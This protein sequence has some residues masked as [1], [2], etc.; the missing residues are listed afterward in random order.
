MGYLDH[1]IF[2]RLIT[3][4]KEVNLTKKENIYHYYEVYIKGKTTTRLSKTIKAISKNILEEVYID[5]YELT[6][7]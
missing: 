5:L 1:N 2:K 4:L 7:L 3:I 6:I